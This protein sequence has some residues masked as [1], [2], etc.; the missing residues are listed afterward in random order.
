[1]S[2]EPFEDGATLGQIGS[3][4]GEILRDDH[5]AMQAR[6]TLER[7]GAIA[8]YTITCGIYGWMVHSCFFA[9]AE[10]ATHAY[11]LIQP[12]LARIAELVPFTHDPEVEQKSE[13]LI[14][15]IELFVERF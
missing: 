14:E 5:Y 11:A 9:D 12:E 2:W 10:A 7:D 15:A 3:E 1:M 6:I 8:P 4:G 13:R